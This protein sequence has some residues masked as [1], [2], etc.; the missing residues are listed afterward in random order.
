M[1]TQVPR[2]EPSRDQYQQEGLTYYRV[3]FV[4]AESHGSRPDRLPLGLSFPASLVFHA[5]IVLVIALTSLHRS[6][7]DF[8]TPVSIEVEVISA[9]EFEAAMRPEAA[10]TPGASDVRL[11]PSNVPVPTQVGP[12]HEA[13]PEFV[14]ATT[15][16]AGRVLTDPGHALFRRDLA[17]LD[18]YERV[19]Q[20]CNVEAAEQ[21][22][23]AVPGSR[24]DTVSASSFAE[25]TLEG[26]VFEA[27]GAAY[28]VDRKWYH[29]SFICTVRADL[30]AVT[31]FAFSL[32]D[33]IPESEWEAH[34]LIA[35]DLEDDD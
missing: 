26:R 3:T 16:R 11:E 17:S 30:E 20:V 10:A 5:A 14:S 6:L 22:L 31:E 1:N 29:L 13:P 4:V 7:L 9:A 28:R 32:G 25:T 12:E 33:H 24:I 27:T 15:L 21:I 19:T 34:N 23:L 2:A 18:P 35:E 8:T